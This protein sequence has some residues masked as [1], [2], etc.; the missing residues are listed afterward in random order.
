M[1]SLVCFARIS[2]LILPRDLD[3]TRLLHG[4]RHGR[5]DRSIVGRVRG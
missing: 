3:A 5:G 1:S 4:S 2:V